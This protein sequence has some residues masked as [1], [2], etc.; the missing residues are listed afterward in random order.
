MNRLFDME[1][2]VITF[3]A[4]ITDYMLLNLLFIVCCIPVVT[5]GAS[6]TALHYVIFKEVFD[7][8]EPGI[9][10]TF[11][12][13]FGQNFKQATAIW[14]GVL[15]VA[16]IIA[17]DV[18]ILTADGAHL[19]G[20]FLALIIVVAIAV[21]VIAMYSLALTARF[22]NTM[23]Q[24]IKNAMLMSIRHAPKSVVMML[25]YLSPFA[26]VMWQ[27]WGIMAVLLVGF[28][29]AVYINSFVRKDIFS[30]YSSDGQSS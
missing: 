30:I 25:V 29:C 18:K 2:P 20:W 28:S 22:E 10:K 15:A 1:G 6:I 13:A 21:F 17:L 7:Q 23:R 14:L 9:F 19:T 11:F 16:A 27:A 24:T 5:I 4:R 8:E 26:L 3:L 12:K